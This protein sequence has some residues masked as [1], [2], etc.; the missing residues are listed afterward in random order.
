MVWDDV[1]ILSLHKIRQRRGKIVVADQGSLRFQGKS[2]FKV[3][4]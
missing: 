2:N 1:E 3:L 4:V